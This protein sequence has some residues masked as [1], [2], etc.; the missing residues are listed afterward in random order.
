M[1]LRNPFIGAFGLDIGDLS[2]KLIQLKRKHPPGKPVEY[3]IKEMRSIALPP[4]YIVNG[5]IQ[6]PEMV[7]KKILQLLGKEG[8]KYPPIKTPW[9]VADLPEPQTFL[10]TIAIETE[11]DNLTEEDVTYQARKHLPFDLNEAYIDWQIVNKEKNEQI[12]KIIIGAVPKVIA[13][14]Y[15]YLLESANLQPIALEIE[16]VAIAR[17]LITANKDY[18]GE[19]RA[20]LDLGATRSSLVIYDHDTIQ[21]S[22]NINFS[23]ELITTALTQKL[24]ID[25]DVAE[26][27][28]IDNGLKYI[29]EK[30]NYLKILTALTDNLIK[31]LKIAINFYEAHFPNPNPIT[32]ITLT[33]GVANL[34]G[35]AST[36][37]RKLKISAH[38]GNTWKNLSNKPIDEKFKKIGMTYSSAVGLA[39]RAAQKPW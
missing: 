23:G 14:S 9:V 22:S 19:A 21:F 25:Y 31:E 34:S 36:L 32:R 13:D 4:G 3:I 10:K 35:L 20:I 24:E 8:K 12:S 18:I 5:E 28:K 37:S 15:T 1:F 11:P 2:I 27:L 17:S 33:G 16:A 7:R 38:P 26:K 30:P 39:L 29:K 6:Q